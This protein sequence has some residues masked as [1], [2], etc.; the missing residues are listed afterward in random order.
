MKIDLQMQK[1][2]GFST[3]RERDNQVMNKKLENYSKQFLN[4]TI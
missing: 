2:F 3:S 1:K 4:L